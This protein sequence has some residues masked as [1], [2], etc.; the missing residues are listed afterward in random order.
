MKTA[1]L[2]GGMAKVN[3][4]LALKTPQRDQGLSQGF[5]SLNNSVVQ[6]DAN[7]R[8]KG[9][10]SSEAGFPHYLFCGIFLL[11]RFRRVLW[12]IIVGRREGGMPTAGP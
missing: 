4:S 5:S 6:R 1:V 3:R 9:K 7:P 12:I 8:Y 11:S 10:S 2:N